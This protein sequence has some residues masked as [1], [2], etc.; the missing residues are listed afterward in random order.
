MRTNILQA[1]KA[2]L[3]LFAML[4]PLLASAHDFKVDGI[5]YKITSSDDGTVAVTFGGETYDSYFNEYKGSVIIP[6]TVVYNEKIYSV[7]SIGELAFRDCSSL[8]SITIPEG[9]ARIG[10]RAFYYCNNLSSIS[11]PMSVTSIGNAAFCYCEKLKSITIPEGVVSIGNGAFSGCYNLTSISIPESVISLGDD[12]L[13]DCYNLT[14]ISVAGTCGNNFTWK[15]NREG[16][17]I[18]KGT[19]AMNK[20]PWIQFND[21]I[22]TVTIT[23]GVTSIAPLAFNR[24]S[25]LTSITIPEG[26]T[27]IGKDAFLRCKNLRTITL[28]SSMRSIG[29]DAFYGCKNLD[30]LICKAVTPPTVS[31]YRTFDD[32]YKKTLR[33]PKSSIEAYKSTPQTSWGHF[34]YIRQLIIAGGACGY[35]LTWTLYEDGNLIVRGTGAMKEYSSS[36]VVPW[37]PYKDA[38]N[39]VVLSEGVTS[40]SSLV[41]EGC[42]NLASVNIPY[43]ITSIGEDAFRDCSNLMFITVPITI[44]RWNKKLLNGAFGDEN[45]K[46][47]VNGKTRTIK[48]QKT[49]QN[50]KR[51]N[52]E[53]RIKEWASPSMPTG[54][55]VGRVVGSAVG[56]V[57]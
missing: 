7:T 56:S 26:V 32:V 30:V 42:E 33:V 49:S 37:Y 9:V 52:L 10:D 43:S 14:S 44:P 6:S 5:Y 45:V 3:A 28:P 53:N 25:N 19:G 4:M 2:L 11:L 16:E 46:L 29:E 40:I 24:C 54:V 1:K 23:K 48:P 41:F 20:I 36:K 35:D 34:W 22:K 13:S 27:S 31:G 17:L 51:G 57:N 21:A 12:V 50:S 55:G 47:K 18:I 38:I 39:T 8:T 15:L